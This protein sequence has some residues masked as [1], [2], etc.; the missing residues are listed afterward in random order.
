[1]AFSGVCPCG[2][3]LSDSEHEVLTLKTALNWDKSITESDLPVRVYQ[4]VCVSCGRTDWKVKPCQS[5][6]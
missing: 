1:M 3:R 4:R 6:P 5:M 2:G